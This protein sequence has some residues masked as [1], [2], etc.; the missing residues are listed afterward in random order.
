MGVALRTIR[1]LLWLQVRLEDRPQDQHRS[2][3]HHA[4]AN[5]R[6]SQR[7]LSCR[8]S[9]GCSPGGP[10]GVD[11]FRSVVLP[12]VRP[13]HFS[14]PYASISSKVS[15]STPDCAV[16]AR[17]RCKATARTS[18]PVDLVVQRVESVVGR[19]PSLWCVTPPATSQP[20]LEVLD[21]SP[22]S[23]LSASS[24]VNLEPR[25]LPST[26]IT[27]LHRYYGPLR[28]P[29]PARPVPR[30]LPVEFTRLTTWGFP[31][32]VGSPVSRHAVVITPVGSL[33]QIAHGSAYSNRSPC[34]PATAAF[35]SVSG[36]SAPTLDPFEACSAFTRVTACLLATPPCGVLSR[37]LRRF[38]YLHRRSD[39]YRPERPLPGGMVT[40][41]YPKPK[42][43]E[44]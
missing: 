23:R 33:G 5:T 36:G 24:C 13:S 6:N 40:P 1:V 9:L 22:I 25:P 21:S 39:S 34:S 11:T 14:S 43:G 38:R 10:A 26:G 4:I 28:H 35:P 19:C 41:G 30:G 32:C 31:C 8:C 27:R 44:H 15:P 12:P 16:L 3:L 17:Q 37:R 42:H 2:H 20:L 7:A 18:S 29:S